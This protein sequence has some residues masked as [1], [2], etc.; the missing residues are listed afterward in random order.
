MG[1]LI[2]D[3]KEGGRC[4]SA[5]TRIHPGDIFKE[6]KHFFKKTGFFSFQ[7]SPGVRPQAEGAEPLS[8]FQLQSRR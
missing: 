8:L 1:N 3:K 2:P 4:P 6:K 7:I 5:L